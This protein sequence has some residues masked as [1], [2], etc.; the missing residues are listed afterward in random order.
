MGINP[1][2]TNLQATR[3]KNALPTSGCSDKGAP[4]RRLVRSI[5]GPLESA[6]TA[7]C[8]GVERAD[9]ESLK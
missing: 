2:K 3:Q 6:S 9:A 1:Q 5:S 7:F 8:V 4:S